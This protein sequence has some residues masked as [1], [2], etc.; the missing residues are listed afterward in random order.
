[1]GAKMRRQLFTILSV[2]FGLCGT[3]A[4]AAN[5]A[6]S[7]ERAKARA[8]KSKR[9]PPAPIIE[10][11]PGP[12][13][14]VTSP[15][16]AA[17]AAPAPAPPPAT[18]S[19]SPAPAAAETADSETNTQDAALDP[20]ALRARYDAL[21]DQV[22]RSRA[23]RE[24]MENA[25]FSTKV[26]FEVRWEANRRYRLD[27]AEVRLDGT[28]IWDATERPITEDPIQLAERAVAPGRHVLTIRLEVHSRDK[29]E[30]GYTSEQNFHVNL[31]EGKASRVRI[32]VDEDGNLPS[33]NPEIEVKVDD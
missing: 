29:L 28:R 25:L 7:A 16:D 14:E 5:K 2:S 10:P 17:T 26:A 24:T 30:M 19:P 32:S 22:F 33:Y 23:R 4:V 3:P 15:D 1:M 21:R 8:A 27:K 13:E 11:A 20:E 31:P 6:R 18:P 9:P 12:D